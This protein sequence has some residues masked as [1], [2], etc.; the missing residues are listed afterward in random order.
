FSA[1]APQPREEPAGLPQRVPAEPDVPEMPES[2]SGKGERWTAP[3]LA[4]IADQLKRADVPQEPAEG[5]DVDAVLGAVRDVP[6]VRSA[7]VRP[8][9]D[10]IHTLRLDLADDADPGQVSRLVARLLEERMGLSAAPNHP[11]GQAP[12]STPTEPSCTG[13]QATVAHATGDQ[14]TV[15]PA[16]GDQATVAPATGDQATVAPATGS[17]GEYG[18]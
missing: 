13:D 4:W 10:G 17:P 15:A 12:W 6:G 9:P 8:N 18:D 16:T 1:V 14:A 11:V 2:E 7:S 3:E 5:L